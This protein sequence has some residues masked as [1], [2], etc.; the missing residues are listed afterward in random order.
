GEDR[1]LHARRGVETGNHPIPELLPTG[2][3]GGFG[4]SGFA[5]LEESAPNEGARLSGRALI[6]GLVRDCPPEPRLGG[7]TSHCLEVV[8]PRFASW[9]PLG[10][11]RRSKSSSSRAQVF[12]SLASHWDQRD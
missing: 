10:R 12:V 8:E 2:L 5:A 7:F 6:R 4:R 1:S 3:A 11:S 9:L